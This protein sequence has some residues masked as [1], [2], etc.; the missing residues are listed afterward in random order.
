MYVLADAQT[1]SCD[2][3][4]STPFCPESIAKCTCVVTSTTSLTKWSF[5]GPNNATYC[6][7]N[8]FILIQLGGSNCGACSGVCGPSFQAANQP[9]AIPSSPCQTSTLNITAGSG[10]NGALASCFDF[11]SNSTIGSV[12]ISIV[13]KL[14][15]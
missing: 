7:N 10:I 15:L 2:S 6:I 3:T 5:T 13:G 1:F 8:N 11:G 14:I 9:P 12:M 4:L